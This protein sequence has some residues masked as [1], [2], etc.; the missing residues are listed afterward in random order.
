VQ[1]DTHTESYLFWTSRSSDRDI[2]PKRSRCIDIAV[3][4]HEITDNDQVYTLGFICGEHG[5]RGF[6]IDQVTFSNGVKD[7]TPA[8][9]PDMR[10]DKADKVRL[11]ETDSRGQYIVAMYFGY[12]RTINVYNVE[13]PQS[14]SALIV[15]LV[16]TIT[17]GRNL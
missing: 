16:Q 5:T 10:F 14:R 12:N 8:L 6:T 11:R 4:R 2:I 7:I 3:D 9:E 1:S 15:K 17:Q 13:V